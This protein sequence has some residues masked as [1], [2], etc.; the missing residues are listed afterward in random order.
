MTMRLVQWLRAAKLSA[1]LGKQAGFATV[2]FAMTI[3]LLVMVTVLGTWLIGLTVTDLR[4]HSAAS[5]AARILAR[6]QELPHNFDQILPPQARLEVAQDL[7]TISVTIR[8]E[9][10]SPVPRLRLPVT[11]TATAVAAREDLTSGY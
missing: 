10:H 6:G 9:A 2:E 11:I 8:M 7:A 1:T 5:S 4:L 3:P